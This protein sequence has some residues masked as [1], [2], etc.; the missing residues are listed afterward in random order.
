MTTLTQQKNYRN[1]AVVD[2]SFFIRPYFAL[3]EMEPL[4]QIERLVVGPKNEQT[5]NWS[6]WK[7]AILLILSP[8]VV[9]GRKV[10]AYIQEASGSPG[11]GAK[12]IRL[13]EERPLKD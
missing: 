6:N 8:V 7:K 11:R 9:I 13:I 3:A 2:F 4:L 1:L 10:V 12:S 5:C